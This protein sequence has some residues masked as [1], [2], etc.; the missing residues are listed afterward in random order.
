[1]LT[2]NNMATTANSVLLAVNL[3]RGE[4]V[5]QADT[6]TL[7]AVDP[8]DEDDE[9]GPG[10]Q[11]LGV[12]ATAAVSPCAAPDC[13]RRFEGVAGG[14]TLDS[15][16]GVS[17]LQFN[18]RGGLVGGVPV[19]LDLCEAGVAGVRVSVSAVGRASTSDLTAAECP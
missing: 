9:W 4:A 12:A 1:M 19:V 7:V 16:A 5:R 6:T 2:R 18:S 11:V 17:A 10:W 15:P 3:A 14:L 8:S 13:L